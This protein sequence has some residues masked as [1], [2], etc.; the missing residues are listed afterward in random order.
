[1]PKNGHPDGSRL[2]VTLKSPWRDGTE[3]ILITPFELLE[4][5]VAIIPSPRKNMVRYHG[6]FAPNA[7]VRREIV[8]DRAGVNPAS[9]KKIRRP[10][11]AKLMARVFSI[12]VLVC[13]RCQSPMQLISFVQDQKVAQDILLSLK[14]TTAPPSICEPSNRTVEYDCDQVGSTDEEALCFDD[15]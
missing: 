13:P 3:K 5:L 10:A 6:F 11:F 8:K 2:L 12:D 4:R 9:N 1:M 15:F 14:M 7:H